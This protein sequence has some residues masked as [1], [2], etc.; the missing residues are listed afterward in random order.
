MSNETAIIIP[1]M[2]RNPPREMKI[3]FKNCEI[4]GK[5]TAFDWGEGNDF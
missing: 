3:A 4:R 1:K 2:Q 5:I